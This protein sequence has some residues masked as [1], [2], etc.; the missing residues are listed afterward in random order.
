MK[1]NL[2]NYYPGSYQQIVEAAWKKTRQDDVACRIR[3]KDYTLWSAA[4]EEIVNRLGWLDAPGHTLKKI[5]YIR[6]TLAALANKKIKDVILLGMGGSSLAAE[7]FNKV[8][9]AQTGYPQLTVLDTTNPSIISNIA[10][11][12]DCD[13]TIFIVSSK[14]GKTMEIT[15]LFYFFYNKARKIKGGA[16]EHFIFITDEGSP[17]AKTARELSPFHVF[18]NNPDIGGRYSA[19]SFFGIFPA[20]IIGID[21]NKLLHNAQS[22]AGSPDDTGILLGAALGALACQGRDKLTLY[23]PPRWKSFGDWLEQLIA[24]ST[25]KEGKGIIPVLDEPEADVSFYAQDRVFVFSQNENDN[26]SRI[27]DLNAA[28]HPVITVNIKDDYDLGSQ[29]YIWEMATAVAAYFLGVNPFDQPDVEATKIH[30]RKMIESYKNKKIIDE[31]KPVL[32]TADGDVYGNTSG[33]TISEVLNNFLAQQKTGDY[34]SLQIYLNPSEEVDTAVTT[35]RAAIFKKYKL[36]VTCGYGPRYLH[37]TGQLHKGGANCGLF[38]QLTKEN[39]MN[40]PIPDELGKESS[41]LS[42]GELLAA[43]AQGDWQALKEKGRRIIRIHFPNDAA[44][45]LKKLAAFL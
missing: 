5:D 15:S 17:L 21:V 24:E 35:L 40:I 36:P 39:L 6:D 41:S 31:E 4:P 22:A 26:F 13:K 29:M 19:L 43:Q 10:Q 16:G 18:L 14:S 20:A 7:T 1:G 38:I 37:S 2:I 33:K 32:A 8:F 27:K 12:I 3:A 9:S 23:L 11:K 34:A 42:F 30:T 44:V 25:G 45:F 28:G